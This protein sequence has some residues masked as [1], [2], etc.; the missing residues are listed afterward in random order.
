MWYD[1]LK[2]Q[3]L[4]NKQKVKLGNIPIP[5]EEEDSCLK[6]LEAWDDKL[7]VLRDK[8]PISY[9]N[10]ISENGLLLMTEES[11]CSLLKGLNDA[12]TD[13]LETISRGSNRTRLELWRYPQG[14]PHISENEPKLNIRYHVRPEIKDLSI[15]L[16]IQWIFIDDNPGTIDDGVQFDGVIRIGWNGWS[17][18]TLITLNSIMEELMKICKEA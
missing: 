7:D 10:S 12:A 14:F 15:T 3:V 17:N 4:G 18:F 2:V 9:D 6:R 11:A 1:I 13:Y 8:Y 5:V 16:V